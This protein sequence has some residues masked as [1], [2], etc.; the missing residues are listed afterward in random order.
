M[1]FSRNGKKLTSINF[2][3][4]IIFFLKKKFFKKRKV[5][6]QY[7]FLQIFYNTVPVLTYS[8]LRKKIYKESKKKNL[9]FKY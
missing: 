8:T 5:T 6:S 7:Y 3:L 1:T 9:S 2:F 4:K